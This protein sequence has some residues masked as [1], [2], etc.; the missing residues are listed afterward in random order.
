MKSRF[1]ILSAALVLMMVCLPLTA[2]S[3]TRILTDLPAGNGVEKAYVSK[4]MIDMGGNMVGDMMAMYRDMIG[5]IQ[6]V[7]IYSCSNPSLI[8][9]ANKE[10]DK[11]LKKYK[12]EILVESEENGEISNIYILYQKKGKEDPI[13]L[14]ILNSDGKEFNVVIVH[15]SLNSLNK[16]SN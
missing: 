10:M 1:F 13:G 8:S 5:D 4:A 2:C 3:Q 15:G 7:E 16:Q 14:T 11:I 12:A 9:S 6:S